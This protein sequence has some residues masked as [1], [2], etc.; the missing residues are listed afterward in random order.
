MAEVEESLVMGT[1]L[2]SNIK[3]MLI[4]QE[5]VKEEEV[6]SMFRIGS[7]FAQS[8]FRLCSVIPDICHERHEYIRVNFYW[9]V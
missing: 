4:T 5:E 7:E 9:P 1:P 3:N 2:P 6:Q 8:M